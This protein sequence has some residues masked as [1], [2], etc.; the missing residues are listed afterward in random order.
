MATGVNT[1]TAKFEEF[2]VRTAS[3]SAAKF[4]NIRKISR[5][6]LS[7]TTRNALKRC[8]K[9]LKIWQ[10]KRTLTDDAAYRRAER[11]V[12]KLIRRSHHHNLL[13]IAT[14]S[15]NDPKNIW[16]HVKSKQLITFVSSLLEDNSADIYY[17]N[18]LDK[19][20]LLNE[21]IHSIFVPCAS[22]A[23]VEF[24]PLPNLTTPE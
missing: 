20:R 12:Q 11:E 9:C 24:F 18:P 19:A 7:P 21:C 15:W 5:Q 16:D 2:L 3:F 22:D 6:S 17:V 8:N 1:L 4:V 14:S 13:S 10:R 23:M